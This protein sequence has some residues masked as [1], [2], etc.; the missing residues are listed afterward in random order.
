[1]DL[2][3]DFIE[4]IKGVWFEL[5]FK[6]RRNKTYCTLYEVH[7]DYAFKNAYNRVHFITYYPHKNRFDT[8]HANNI[9]VLKRMHRVN[10]PAINRM[11]Q[12][13]YTQYILRNGL[14]EG[15]KLSNQFNH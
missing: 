6:N 9:F 3:H 4:S 7:G 5:D 14:G 11:L 15:E 8:L 10:D 12:G 13:K 1:M 2:F